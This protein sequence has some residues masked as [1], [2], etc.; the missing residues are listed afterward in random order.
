MSITNTPGAPIKVAGAPQIPGLRFRGFRGPDDYPA[1]VSVIENS[2]GP[3]GIERTESVEDVIRNYRHL[4]NCDPYQDM[5][6]AEV[7]GQ[8][9]G[10]GRTWWIRED[11]GDRR[12]HFFAFLMPEWREKGIRRAMVRYLE[13]RMR[14]IAADH[15]AADPKS[16]ETW[17]SDTEM[18]WESL[19]QSM[20]YEAVRYA[21][22]MVRRDLEEI[23]NL[24]LPDGLEVRPAVPE[25]HTQIWAAAREAFRDLSGAS[26]QWWTDSEFEAWQEHPTFQPRLWQVAWDGDE[27]AGMV[28]NFIDEAQNE[29]YHRRRGYTETICVRRPWR[30]RGLAKALIARSFQVLKDEGMTEAALGVDTDNPSGALNLYKA[31]GFRRVKSFTTYRKPLDLL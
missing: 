21:Y 30:K 23:P 14:R 19:L 11:A 25:H 29:E 27:V 8:P 5:V 4:T 20:G 13:Q 28:L 16:F 6:F 2:K 12:Y 3:D 24:S 15:P 10:Y 17:A 1:M 9:V 26:E 31:M 22:D 18:H 7:D